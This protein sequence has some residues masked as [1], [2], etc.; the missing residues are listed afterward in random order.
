M[1]SEAP[2]AMPNEGPVHAVEVD[3]FFMDRDA[4]TNGEFAAFVKAT[5]YVTVAERAPDASALLAQLPRGNAAP[6]SEL[7][8]PGSLVFAPTHEPVDLRDWSR[9]WRWMPGANWRHPESPESSIV[10]R[11]SHPVVQV[12]WDDAVAYAEWAGKRLPAEAEWS[13]RRA[14]APSSAST[15]GATRQSTLRILKLTFMKGRCRR[16]SP[17]HDRLGRIRLTRTPYATWRATFGSG[18]LIGSTPTRIRQITR[19]ASHAIPRVPRQ[20]SPQDR[21]ASFAADHSYAAI[22]TAAA[23]A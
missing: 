5:G 13:S 10:G 18:R 21:L 2:R 7:L 19:A 22:R 20:Q 6:P 17:A 15:R 4:V 14:A 3:G 9:W 11:D 12:A 23:I 16:I 8:A 1:G